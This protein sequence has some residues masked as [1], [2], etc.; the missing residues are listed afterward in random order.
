MAPLSRPRASSAGAAARL[1]L[2]EMM[3]LGFRGLPPE[4]S[5]FRGVPGCIHG[6]RGR[7]TKTRLS[8]FVEPSIYGEIA[9]RVI[10]LL[11]RGNAA[12]RA[13]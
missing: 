12:S 11:I 3:A 8:A 4:A 7:V 1:S 10:N 6:L 13:H 2:A 9:S 5:A